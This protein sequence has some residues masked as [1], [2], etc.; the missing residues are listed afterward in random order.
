MIAC[1]M[2]ALSVKERL[3]YSVLVAKLALA[4]MSHCETANGFELSLDA[5]KLRL[6]DL[7]EWMQLES[8]CCPFLDFEVAVGGGENTAKLRLAGGEGVKEFLR[9]EF[10]LK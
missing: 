7:G 9:A 10:G 5:N 8:R 1:N 6:R 4:K 2:H 3:R